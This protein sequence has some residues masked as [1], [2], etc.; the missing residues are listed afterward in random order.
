MLP[1][2]LNDE[3][4]VY[5]FGRDRRQPKSED[6]KHPINQ[7]MCGVLW[8]LKHASNQM[9]PM[10]SETSEAFKRRFLASKAEYL[11]KSVEEL[12]DIGW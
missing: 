5:G 11:K 3:N 10:P 4:V 8:A 2:S 6:G 9:L 1:A 7:S 12:E